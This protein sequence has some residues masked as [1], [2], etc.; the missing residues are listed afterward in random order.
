[1]SSISRPPSSSLHVIVNISPPSL[2]YASSHV[3]APS[4]R[5]AAAYIA[6]AFAA[7]VDTCIA[8]LGGRMIVLAKRNTSLAARKERP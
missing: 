8:T 6:P 2:S 5:D 1:M 4:R 7:D 3:V